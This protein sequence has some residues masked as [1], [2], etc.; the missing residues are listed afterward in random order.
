[1]NL[2]D[3]LN[4][5]NLQNIVKEYSEVSNKCKCILHLTSELMDNISFKGEYIPK[6]LSKLETELYNYY[7]SIYAL[8]KKIDKFVEKTDNAKNALLKKQTDSVKPDS[9]V[10]RPT[11]RSNTR[12]REN[13]SKDTRNEDYII[14]FC[15]SGM[16]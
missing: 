11:K 13:C 8:T 5:D 2:N 16:E 1:M 10:S 7:R 4:V 12:I 15:S 9:N 14:I 6:E 3:T